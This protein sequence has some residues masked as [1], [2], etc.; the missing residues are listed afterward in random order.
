VILK[1]ADAVLLA[2][3]AIVIIIVVPFMTSDYWIFTFGTVGAVAISVIGLNVAL[4]W[5]G[6]DR[7]AGAA[8]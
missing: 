5:A 4:G 1:R 2:L 7:V 8:V 3:C 6:L